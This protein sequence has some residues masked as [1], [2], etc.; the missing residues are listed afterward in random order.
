VP[1]HA[2][3]GSGGALSPNLCI[4]RTSSSVLHTLRAA[5]HVKRWA[6][7][8][9]DPRY[10]PRMNSTPINSPVAPAAAG[11]YS[12]A[13]EVKGVQRLLFISGQIPESVDGEAPDGF[14][15]QARLVWAN[16]LAQLEAAGM[17]IN[18][19][20]KV[21]T[22]LSSREYAIANREVR[23]EALGT[24]APALTV[25]SAGIFDERWLLE[26]EAIAAE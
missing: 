3:A 19:L 4:E 22:F 10:H 24:H 15:A 18:N 20:V 14:H 1:S 16:V 13:L 23:Q 26:I 2:P 12:Q 7:Q 17:S 5:A 9:V 6:A 11:G 25:I 8:T 21:T